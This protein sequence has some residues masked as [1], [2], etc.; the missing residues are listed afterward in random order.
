MTRMVQLP[1]ML[2][3]LPQEDPKQTRIHQFFDNLRQG[4]LTTTRCA[5]CGETLWQP[6]VAC[7]HCNSDEM[8]WID[9]P[10]EGKLYAYTA[11]VLGAPMGFESE[12]PFVVA[13]VELDMGQSGKMRMFSRI[14]DVTY[15]QCTIGKKVWFKMVDCEDG[16]VFFRFTAKRPA[17]D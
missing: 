17:T 15:E 13:I 4:R 7:P 10:R 5:A 8:E 16:R 11:M 14:D 1:F 9:L 2:D 3:F 6:R 12:V